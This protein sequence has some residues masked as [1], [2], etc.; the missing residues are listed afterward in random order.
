MTR[1]RNCAGNLVFDPEKQKLVCDHCGSEFAP[2]EFG[3]SEKEASLDNKAEPAN[4]VY[5]TDAKEFMDCYVYTCGSCG[6]EIMINGSEVS[7]K[8]IYCG[9]SAVV[10]SRISKQRRP[11]YILPFKTTREEA[12]EVVRSAFKRGVF[13]PNAVKNFS[14]EN[15]RG[16]YI[17]YWIV[18]FEHKEKAVIR[19]MVGT[20]RYT[21]MEYFGRAGRMKLK[22]I[23]LDASRMLNDESSARLE[24]Y[25][26]SEMVP[27]D[28]D[29]LLG[30]YSDAS[31]ITYGDL[32]AA[33]GKR[34]KTYF[35]EM[36]IKGINARKKKI[37]QEKHVTTVDYGTLRYAM[38]PVWFITYEYKGQHNTV[39]VNGQTGKIVCGV[40][41]NKTLFFTL[42]AILG[43]A[44]TAVSFVI[45]RTVMPPIFEYTTKTTTKTDMI[46]MSVFIA[47][48]IAMFAYGIRRINRVIKSESL[49]QANAIFNF[50]K[51]R[52]E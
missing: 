34:A 12:L 8:C 14:A 6:G 22:D 43:T 46:I 45:F 18:D 41:W 47:G 49:T 3:L 28:E 4:K 31:D 19:G 20:G 9:N 15:V 13:T 52:Q 25:D 32:K 33:A 35:D 51:K 7:T 30:F 48:A 11:K 27:F 1:C 50:V 44:L 2:E 36:V 40:P 5:G 42:M 24:P 17:P 16:I 10:F 29:Y 37:I 38:L 39:L 23:P 21:R 26:L